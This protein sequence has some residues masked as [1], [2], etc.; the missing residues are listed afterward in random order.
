MDGH[1]HVV[2]AVGGVTVG[3]GGHCPLGGQDVSQVLLALLK[4]S[5]NVP[6]Q[7]QHGGNIKLRPEV[8]HHEPGLGVFREA[9]GHHGGDEPPDPHLL[10]LLL[11]EHGSGRHGLHKIH[12]S[13]LGG[14]ALLIGSRVASLRN[15]LHGGYQL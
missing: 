9:E 14:K 10:G 13:L 4:P 15:P 7:A 2:P 8:V 11:G 3:G 12:L 5:V 1:P 6:A